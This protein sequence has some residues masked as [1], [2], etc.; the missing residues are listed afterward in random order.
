MYPA[1]GRWWPGA[2]G[3]S[4]GHSSSSWPWLGS[5]A[6]AGVASTAGPRQTPARTQ[7]TFTCDHPQS[8]HCI[9]DTAFPALVFISMRMKECVCKENN[10]LSLNLQIIE[11]GSYGPH[12]IDTTHSN[13]FS[14]HFRRKEEVVLRLSTWFSDV[15]CGRRWKITISRVPRSANH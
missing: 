10:L 8:G 2:E 5:G 15:S 4:G 7:S 14:K 3:G 6:E 11:F 9:T 13:F 12:H 1:P